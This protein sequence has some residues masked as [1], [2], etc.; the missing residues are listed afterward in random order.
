MSAGKSYGYAASN[1][2]KMSMIS[3]VAAV[4]SKPDDDDEV[5]SEDAES[6]PASIKMPKFVPQQ[7]IVTRIR[8][9]SLSPFSLS[10]KENIRR[11]EDV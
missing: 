4:D 6:E 8:R 10:L 2:V 3:A 5:E 7:L 9:I 11:G 1:L